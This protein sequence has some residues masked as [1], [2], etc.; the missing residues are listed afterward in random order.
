[1]AV[2]FEPT[3]VLPTHAFEACSFGRSDTPPSKRVQESRGA[4]SPLGGEELL[5]ECSALVS[6]YSAGDLG[7]VVEP[8]IPNHVP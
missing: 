6:Q 5:E 7:T 2:G 3:V 8:L 1:M 4:I